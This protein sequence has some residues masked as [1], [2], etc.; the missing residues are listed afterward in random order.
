MR[1]FDSA[2][3]K[4]ASISADLTLA[5]DAAHANL[6]GNWRMPTKAE[7]QEMYN[8]CNVVWTSDYNGT[9]VA[10]Q[11]LTSKVNGNSVFFPRRRSLHR[12]VREKHGRVQL[13]GFLVLA[14]RRVELDQ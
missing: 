14:L 8:N 1:A 10:G 3:Y 9:G 7:C 11:L 6:G 12:F 2:S 13:V 4:A 5:Q